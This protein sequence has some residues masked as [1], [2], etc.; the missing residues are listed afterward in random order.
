MMV[1]LA[2]GESVSVAYAGKQGSGPDSEVVATKGI[3]VDRK[4]LVGSS[5]GG[6]RKTS[7]I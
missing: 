4:I 6:D 5:Y 7:D 2:K 3:V 1:F